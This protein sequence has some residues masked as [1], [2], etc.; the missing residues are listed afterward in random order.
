[1]IYRILKL[2]LF[3]LKAVIVEILIVFYQIPLEKAMDLESV[4][5]CY[6]IDMTS[7]SS[8]PGS[9]MFGGNQRITVNMSNIA[10]SME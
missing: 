8:S 6:K 2:T 1:M 10:G 3:I 4:M 5:Q 7:I 9:C